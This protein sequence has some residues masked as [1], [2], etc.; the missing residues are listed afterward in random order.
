MLQE[1]NDDQTGDIAVEAT[2][3]EEYESAQAFKNL[4]PSPIIGRKSLKTENNF[5]M[6]GQ[7]DS[8]LN[9]SFSL[10][11][12][13]DFEDTSDDNLFFTSTPK[14]TEKFIEDM[15]QLLK[16]KWI[17]RQLPPVKNSKSKD[18]ADDPK[19]LCWSFQQV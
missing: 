6:H 13:S 19:K 15:K 1:F 2:E 16:K 10:L 18:G 5:E 8:N 9:E 4:D 7:P 11:D 3:I 17:Q 12:R 14:H